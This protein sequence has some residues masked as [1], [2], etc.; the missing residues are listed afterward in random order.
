MHIGHNFGILNLQDW[1]KIPMGQNIHFQLLL[2]E[3]LKL[4][5]EEMEL[6]KLLQEMELVLVGYQHCQ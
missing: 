5:Q 4:L 3:L 6:L 1:H 2:L